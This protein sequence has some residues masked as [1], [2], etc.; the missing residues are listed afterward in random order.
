MI[1]DA[2][3]EKHGGTRLLGGI[4]HS[5]W[6]FTSVIGSIDAEPQILKM[7]KDLG[8]AAGVE[9][10]ND[11]RICVKGALL[12][13]PSMVYGTSNINFCCLDKHWNSIF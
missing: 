6:K 5:G 8:E 12:H 10:R 1:D 13:L 11:D 4:A 7:T 3:L 2:A 9:P